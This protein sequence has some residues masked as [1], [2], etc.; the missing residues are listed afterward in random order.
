[1]LEHKSFLDIKAFQTKF[2]NCFEIGDI[3][4]IS[5]KLCDTQTM[6]I[7]RKMLHRY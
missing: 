7:V 1:M 3:I 4:Q 2:V 6:Q 5:E